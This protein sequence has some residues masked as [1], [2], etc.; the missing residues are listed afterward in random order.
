MWV[1][2]WSWPFT[3]RFTNSSAELI[4]SIFRYADLEASDRVRD[5]VE[6]DILAPRELRDGA[7]IDK[8]KSFGFID[9]TFNGFFNFRFG[10]GLSARKTS[11]QWTNQASSRGMVGFTDRNVPNARIADEKPV[12]EIAFLVD[13]P[14]DGI[15][16]RQ[17]PLTGGAR[18]RGMWK[19]QC[20]GEQLM[21][22]RRKR[23]VARDQPWGKVDN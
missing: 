20:S 13:D 10:R 2:A 22:C 21:L 11:H 23:L 1:T 19:D 16:E 15:E 9:E 5:P 14:D 18:P 17:A 7:Q 3:R 4:L 8:Q 6:C 12:G